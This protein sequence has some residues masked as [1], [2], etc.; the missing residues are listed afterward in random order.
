MELVK[1]EPLII[2]GVAHYTLTSYDPV[3]VEVDVPPVTDAD[4]DQAM[5]MSVAQL[6]GTPASLNDDA[7]IRENFEGVNNALE[8]HEALREQ[9]LFMNEQYAEEQK[10]VKCSIELAR[11]LMQRVPTKR[12]SEVRRMLDAMFQAS[13]NSDGITMDQFFAQ[14]GMRREEFENMLDTRAQGEAETEAALDAWVEHFGMKV[15]D[16]ELPGL[17]GIDPEQTEQFMKQMHATGEI[18]DARVAALRSKALAQVVNECECT[19]HHESQD[20]QGGNG[21]GAG[22]RLKLV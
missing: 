10:T 12:V 11:R 14:S 22:P 17:L 18:E 3:S 20:G 15:E 1:S 6:G 7:W 19:Y 8:L 5:Q 13:L 2:D 16:E 9:M 21:N 4:I